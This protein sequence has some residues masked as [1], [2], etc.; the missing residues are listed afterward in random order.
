MCALI[1]G[2]FLADPGPEHAAA[3][4]LH[5]QDLCRRK[6]R[7]SERAD[8]FGH[9]LADIAGNK[10]PIKRESNG[11][12]AKGVSANPRG[13]PIGWRGALKRMAGENGERLWE[14]IM[15]HAEGKPLIPKLP[16]GREGPPIIPT[17]ES[18]LRAAIELAHM[19]AGKP[20]TQDQIMAAE[21]ASK[22]MAEIRALSD[23]ELRERARNILQKGLDQL[24]ARAN[25]PEMEA[26][27]V[28]PE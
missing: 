10:S 17:P 14:L 23:G 20:V 11:H 12:F 9:V 6:G 24:D 4:G 18:S 13:G 15:A 16:D 28:I 27:K 25:R 8:T 7:M 1:R 3:R 5:L 21:Q 22:E 26:A 19:F 2:A